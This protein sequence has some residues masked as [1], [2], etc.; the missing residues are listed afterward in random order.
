MTWETRDVLLIV[1]AVVSAAVT[2]Q[3][4]RSQVATLTRELEKTASGLLERIKALEDSRDKLGARIGRLERTQAINAAIARYAA[5]PAL[6]TAIPTALV[7][8][9]DDSG[10]SEG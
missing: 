10:E 8:G 7:K 2:I 4:V 3:V 9:G 6:G 5:T 1:G